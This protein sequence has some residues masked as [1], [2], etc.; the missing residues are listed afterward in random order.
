MNILNDLA[1]P[2]WVLTF[3]V[4]YGLGSLLV[5]WGTVVDLLDNGELTPPKELVDDFLIVGVSAGVLALTAGA[6]MLIV[7]AA[8]DKPTEWFLNDLWV[9]LAVILIVA[10]VGV[11][12]APALVLIGALALKALFIAS[13][14]L[15][16]NLVI[17]PLQ[18]WGNFLNRVT[19]IGGREGKESNKEEEREETQTEKQKN[20]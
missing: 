19:G 11:F 4:F 8:S 13:A 20:L 9:T 16:T 5:V 17:K 18:A 14:F 3:F 10:L 15:V 1:I 12:I 7:D 2:Q 6:L